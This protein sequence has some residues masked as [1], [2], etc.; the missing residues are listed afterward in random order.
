MSPWVVR[1][2]MQFGVPII[3]TTHGGYA[4]LRGNNP[5]LYEHLRSGAW[6]NDWD[7]REFD[8]M[9]LD[10]QKAVESDEVS[11]DWLAYA[12]AWQNIRDEPAMFP[13]SS[14]ARVGSLWGLVPYQ[15]TP[16][17]GH[18]NRF[19]RYATGVWYA[20]EFMLAALG[21]WAMG[22]RL[23]RAP[24]VWGTLL[25]ASFT[26]AHAIISASLYQRAPLAPVL[27]LLA[28]TG[29]QGLWAGR[30]TVKSVS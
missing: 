21:A 19:L 12:L 2:Q 8:E 25:L 13:L 17:E 16:F 29:A 18:R 1:N 14:V 3:T 26:A 30:R 24:W 27:A 9:W 22:R 10:E 5:S 28:A 23:A 4:L 11:R 15:S 20:I 6:G 7:S